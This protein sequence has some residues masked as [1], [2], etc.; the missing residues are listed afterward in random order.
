VDPAFAIQLMKRDAFK[1][2][3]GL[4]RRRKASVVAPKLT[5]GKRLEGVPEAPKRTV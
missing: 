3:L 2:S 1:G 5:S 4:Y